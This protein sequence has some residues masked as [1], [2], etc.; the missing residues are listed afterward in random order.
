M[1][2][3]FT[4]VGNMTKKSEFINLLFTAEGLSFLISQ[5]KKGCN[6]IDKLK[7]AVKNHVKN[8]SE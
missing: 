7:K 6:N 2:K 3:F 4:V 8:I 1:D 5:Y